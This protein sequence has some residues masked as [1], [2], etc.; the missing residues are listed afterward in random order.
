MNEEFIQD[1][2]N[3]KMKIQ[4]IQDDVNLSPAWSRWLWRLYDSAAMP[5]TLH[6]IMKGREMKGPRHDR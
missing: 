5:P 1:L 3:L 4:E 6:L 2:H